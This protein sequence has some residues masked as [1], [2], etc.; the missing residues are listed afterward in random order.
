MPQPIV[1]KMNIEQAMPF[2][3]HILIPHKKTSQLVPLE[4]T[5]VQ[6]DWIRTIN[7]NKYSVCLKGR[8]T[9]ISTATKF[10]ILLWALNHPGLTANIFVHKYD[11]ANEFV[12]DIANWCEFLQIPKFR[13][14]QC[15]LELANGAKI[16]GFSGKSNT[17]GGKFS[18]QAR[19]GSC[20][21]LYM[22][23]FAMYDNAPLIM[24]S[25][26]PTL[27]RDGKFIIE[28]TSTGPGTEFHKLFAPDSNW[29]QRFYSIEQHDIYQEPPPVEDPT[30]ASNWEV[31][32]EY[33]FSSEPHAA[34]FHKQLHTEL[35]GD[36]K[37]ALYEFPVLESHA[38]ETFEG[39]FFDR[40]TEQI[41]Y[42]TDGP[43]KGLNVYKRPSAHTRYVI[44]YD[45]AGGTK[46]DNAAICVLD[47]Y[48][49]S[50]CASWVNNE[51]N[52]DVQCERLKQIYK[53]YH[54]PVDGH[55]NQP[56]GQ[57]E[58][59]VLE[60]NGLGLGAMAIARK[61]LLPITP[62]HTGGG[63]YNK[64]NSKYF[65]FLAVKKAV[66]NYRLVGDSLLHEE[67]EKLARDK[68]GGFVGPDDMISAISFA[69]VYINKNPQT[70]PMSL[71]DRSRV[72]SVDKYLKPKK[73]Y[74]P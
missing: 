49:G 68:K 28:S 44:G 45:P 32:Q 29:T 52:L 61:L 21:L 36:M 71:I 74:L 46:R 66:D 39:R 11:I 23:E 54:Y 50:L 63:G 4:L 64:E 67:T 59:I 9:F 70:K 47:R 20:H 48:D 35:S 43:V 25:A 38:W 15:R 19:G 42:F 51:L 72:F 7:D 6:Q 60:K 8:Q 73:V 26:G 10:Y 58:A 24:S 53:Y 55:P 18:G 41:E 37:R 1:N 14:S 40:S 2:S 3:K 13:N 31:Y 5:N 56:V 22:S 27:S 69:L 62:V 12:Q 30:W 17:S 33:G 65:N 16:V 57:V 34:W